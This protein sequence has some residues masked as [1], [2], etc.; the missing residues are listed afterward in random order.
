MQL[1]HE[2]ME[3]V[4][5]TSFKPGRIS[6]YQIETYLNSIAHSEEDSEEAG[7]V[8]FNQFGYE[9]AKLS[10]KLLSYLGYG[11]GLYSDEFEDYGQKLFL[12]HSLSLPTK[13]FTKTTTEIVRGNHHTP[14]HGI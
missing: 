13:R 4:C 12:I 14:Q 6:L 1:V 10:R 7:D 5:P 8:K 3:L 11:S 2:G 9:R